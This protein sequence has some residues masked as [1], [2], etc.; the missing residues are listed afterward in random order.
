MNRP[1]CGRWSR[2]HTTRTTCEWTSACPH[3]G[4]LLMFD[5][6]GPFCMCSPAAKAGREEPVVMVQQQGERWPYHDAKHQFNASKTNINRMRGVLLNRMR[7]VLLNHVL[8]FTKDMEVVRPLS[9]LPIPPLPPPPPP[10]PPPCTS[11][12]PG[13]LQDS[14]A[15]TEMRELVWDNGRWRPPLFKL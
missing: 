8:G 1:S 4:K 7:G 13:P 5:L 3:N 2:C 10:P 9:P 11:S 15:M 6:I 12:Q 14:D